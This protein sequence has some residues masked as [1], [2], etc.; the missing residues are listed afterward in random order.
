[1]PWWSGNRSRIPCPLRDDTRRNLECIGSGLSPGSRGACSLSEH[2]P[3]P[4]NEWPTTT[5]VGRSTAS[6]RGGV[7]GSGTRHRHGVSR[8]RRTFGRRHPMASREP[9]SA[10][11]RP[12]DR[13]ER[14]CPLLGAAHSSRRPDLRAA[15]HAAGSRDVSTRSTEQSVWPNRRVATASTKAG[16]ELFLSTLEVHRRTLSQPR[17]RLRNLEGT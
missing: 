14:R 1:M 4:R 17:P 6:G 5:I 8:A 3:V 15:A 11:S 9:V 7:A 13:H 12:H 16:R 10:H 2:E